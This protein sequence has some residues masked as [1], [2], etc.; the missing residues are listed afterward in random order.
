MNP[1][2]L[3]SLVSMIPEIYKTFQ[4]AR[5][6]GQ[7]TAGLAGL[8]RPEYK[9]P[10]A[11]NRSMALSTQA[12]ANGQMPGENLMVDRANQTTANAFAQSKEAGNPMGLLAALH[13]QNQQQLGNIGTQS[14]QYHN[15][16]QQQ[17]QTML[18]Q[19]A[20]FQDQEWQMN[21]FAPYKD[22]SQEYRDI[23]G[24][25]QQNF[26]NG[27][28]SLS[29][30]ATRMMMPGV[31]GGNGSMGSGSGVNQQG[32]QDAYQQYL[33]NQNG[34]GYQSSVN[35]PFN[36]NANPNNPQDPANFGINWSQFVKG[37]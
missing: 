20:N 35:A 5:Q 30:M 26:Y 8:K 6:I 24:G 14:A 19:K 3:G 25:G 27:L 2:M 32:L 4:G 11:F 18:G 29:G 21:K 1:L 13:G 12:Y 33:N 16:L 22:K 28:S 17:F 23:I 9:T 34:G 10:E 36:N 31:A 37:Q 15:Q 7:G